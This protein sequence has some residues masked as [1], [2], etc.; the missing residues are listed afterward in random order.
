MTRVIKNG[1]VVTA[2][3]TWKADVLFQHG[4]IVA[5]GSDLHADHEL[6]ATVCCCDVLFHAVVE[7]AQ[8]VPG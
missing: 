4:K 7:T 3:R 5:I 2:D 1:T 8:I 6:D